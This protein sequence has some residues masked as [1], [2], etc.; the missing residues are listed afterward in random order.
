MG[1]PMKS[2]GE[3]TE[4]GAQRATLAPNRRRLWLFRFGAMLIVPALFFLVLELALRV[5]GYGY[6]PD[7]FLKQ[8]I[9]G[10]SFFVQNEDFSR[11]FFPPETMRQPN[12]LRM[13]AEKPPGSIR[14]FV[15]GESAAMGDPEPAFG[16]A[17]YLEVLLQLRHPEM[18]FE[19]VNVSFTAINSHVLLPL[20]RECA[21]HD[22]DLWLIY[23]GN[24]EMVGPFG[25][26][27][28]LGAQAPPRPMVRL[29]TA[30]QRLRT[31]QLAMQL[32]RK[33]QKPG[34][35]AGSW[36][37]MAMFEKQ[38]VAP[39]SPKRGA[40]YENFTENLEDML[41]CGLDS[42][43]KILLNTVAVNLRDSPPFASWPDE[44]LSSAERKRFD[45]LFA[46]GRHAQIVTRNATNAA[47][48]FAEAAKCDAGF[49]E[50]HY[51]RAMCLEQTG[52][53]DM[54][55]AEYQL[56]C[57][58]DAL[59]FRTDSRLNQAIR[60]AA[61]RHKPERLLVVD[62]ASALAKDTPA[63]FCGEETFYEH[64]HF[65]FDGGYRLGLV[66]AKSVEQMLPQLQRHATTNDWAT[67]AQSER[68][69]G[70]SD[71][72]RKLVLQSVLNRLAVAPLSSQFNQSERLQRLANRERDL[73]SGANEET[74]VEA[75]ALYAEAIAAR[76]DDHYVR[77][78]FAVF[79]ESCGDRAGALREWHKVA[80]LL[81]HDFLPWFEIGSLLAKQGNHL[82][83]QDNFRQALAR[84]PSLVEGWSELGQSLGAS[85]EFGPALAAFERA[86]ALR[87]ADPVLWA[88]RARALA[89]LERRTEAI[90]L[91]RKA[92]ELNPAYVEAH[93]A[94][95]DQ[96]SASGRISE[97]IAA[98]ETALN[99]KPDYALAHLNLGV[100][101][102][103]QNRFDE[104]ILEFRKTLALEPDNPVAQDYLRQVQAQKRGA[105]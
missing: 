13:R 95:G 68:R 34:K 29:V 20:A 50:A 44:T 64:V 17:R 46:Q 82:E 81:P 75:R 103:R 1:R 71:W 43:A 96:F 7:F 8:N 65:N 89:G 35:T 9:D 23:M 42:G 32:V 30:I 91:Y 12:A 49:A 52:Q 27:T 88:Y 93:V 62:A 60:D 11:R 99:L 79:L 48:L 92:I 100:M 5:A 70:L 3:P 84:R 58:T 16:P 67:Q 22:G 37:G 47:Q 72:N 36:G 77:E 80:E 104:A 66:W 18:D 90:A 98:Y 102:A 26:A 83:A 63:G 51:R 21:Q 69:L 39:K 6:N 56:A 85:Q 2:S 54:A 10:K 53:L 105:R 28:I 57:D 94:L 4:S 87:P 24:N 78:A 19:V 101:F 86:S 59:P 97:A 25:A 31:G 38:R 41:Q 40:V 14:I 76:P 33:L 15:L 73:L 61:T 74:V 55:R 45:E